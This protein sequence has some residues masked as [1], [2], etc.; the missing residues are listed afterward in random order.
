MKS[1]LPLLLLAVFILAYGIYF[2]AYSIQR[3]RAFLTH[4]SDLGQMD[5]AIW[6]TLHGH[7]LESTRRGGEQAPRLTDHVEPIYAVV[8]L[9]FL[10]YD[11]VEALLILQ[12][13]A[14]AIGALAVFWIA[15]RRLQN[16]WSA[17]AFAAMYLLFPALEAANLAEF[18]AATLAPAPLLFAYHYGEQRAWKR[19]VLFSLLALS[20]KEEIALLVLML[21][22][23]FTFKSV[24]SRQSPVASNSQLPTSNLQSLISNLQPIPLAIALLS[25]AWFLLAVFVIIPHF[26]PVGRSIY[27]CRYVVSEDCREIA[28]GLFL[29]E[30]ATYL[31]QLFASVGFGAL[32]DPIALLLGLPLIAANV[33]SNYPAQYSGTYH[34]SAPLVPYFVL[35]A[36]G[37]AGWL[38]GRLRGAGAQGSKGAGEQEELSSAPPHPRT[39]APLRQFL[40]VALMFVIALGYHLVAGYTPIGGAFAWPEIT[41]HDQLFARFENQIP[42][43]AV[44]ST[45]AALHPHLS[46][47][48]VIYRYPTV[49]D[50]DYV[51]VDVGESTTA[52]PIDF[53][54]AY[55]DLLENQNFGIR[56]AADG[57]ILL[58]RGLTEKTLPDAF[59]SFAR[60]SR[61]PEHPR[62]IDFGDAVHLLGY[63][64]DADQW[65]RAVV[66]LYFTPLEN[67]PRDKNLNLFA[68][69][70]DAAGN[71]RTDAE[72]PPLTILFW[73][74][75]SMWRPNEVV[76]A[77]TLPLD[78]G[79]SA[80]L[81]FGVVGGADWNDTARRL[82]I[83]NATAPL[84]DDAT[85]AELGVMVRQG[86]GY[87]VKPR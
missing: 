31:A 5:Q 13:F 43:D 9:A 64:V 71:P 82:K 52:N 6:N 70:A 61:Q 50:A 49:K 20:V 28:R 35:G 80:R 16:Y 37:G 15:R 22:L 3:H 65:G 24:V 87:R 14:I 45:T 68:F 63:D 74:P 2:S 56:D 77:E 23:W 30:R 78:V 10:V 26:A 46:H 79:E 39:P 84:F 73:Y 33:L 47:R 67:I 59:Y 62:P 32:F 41:P 69:Y 21:G 57:Y 12:S 34:Y 8:S 81:A 54:L 66:R 42:R 18:H 7:F 25:A 85:W 4:A 58:Q 53:R 27:T 11:S 29:G 48:R 86:N 76:V 72:I 44:I 36:I 40:V 75:T 19:F 60:T 17:L 83:S 1:R 51:L 55:L 38:V